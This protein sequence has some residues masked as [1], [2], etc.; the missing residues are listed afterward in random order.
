M[1]SNCVFKE[2]FNC[3]GISLAHKPYMTKV[4]S[5]TDKLTQNES[6][7]SAK[8]KDISNYTYYFAP[9]LDSCEV[10][11]GKIDKSDIEK[12]EVIKKEIITKNGSTTTIPS[13]TS[14]QD[15]HF[16]TSTIRY[17]GKYN[18]ATFLSLQIENIEITIKN[19]VFTFS[20]I[21]KALHELM[22][23]NLL[24]YGLIESNIMCDDN[25]HYPIIFDFTI[26]VDVSNYQES[27]IMQR[28]KE[29]NNYQ[30]E[31]WCIEIFLLSYMCYKKETSA[32][33]ETAKLTEKD[34]DIIIEQFY[35]RAGGTGVGQE[36]KHNNSIKELLNQQIENKTKLKDFLL[37]FI[38]QSYDDLCGNL[39]T[40]AKS[41]DIYSLAIMYLK[42][43]FDLKLNDNIFFKEFIEYLIAIITC[44]PDIRETIM[45]SKTIEQMFSNKS[46]TQ[47]EEM[48]KS[49]YL[50]DE[51][52]SE[53]QSRIQETQSI[54][55]NQRQQL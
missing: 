52:K 26:S 18:L 44:T 46:R 24:Y 38:G 48:K 21:Q 13:G 47:L 39:I 49:Y 22:A 16:R 4:Q 9:F 29:S 40:Y 20:Y 36:I 31:P 8:I 42:I 6:E 50:T 37:R 2:G 34:I 33:N 3:K 35:N 53:I 28:M 5:I 54:D 11:L 27:G 10:S 51:M 25:T 1:L 17:I 30:Y 45:L 7:I 14:S 43:L 23:N 41:W 12:C 55:K 32:D 19:I 15:Q